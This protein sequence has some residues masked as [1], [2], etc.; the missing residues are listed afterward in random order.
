MATP[1][2]ANVR[3]DRIEEKIDNLASAMVSLARAEEKIDTLKRDHTNGF[4]R[5]NRFS[6]KL[7]DIEKKVDSNA[8]TVDF[9]HKLFW[10]CIATAVAGVAS[11]I[12][13]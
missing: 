2:P 9:I 3:L 8:K 4:D 10:I 1:S 7:D 11:Q 12:W 6:E 13:M 5:M